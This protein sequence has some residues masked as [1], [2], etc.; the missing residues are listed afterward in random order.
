MTIMIIFYYEAIFADHNI[1]A[2]MIPFPI[3]ANYR[4]MGLGVADRRHLE[5]PGTRT[6]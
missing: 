4:I 2:L 3:L 6:L 1:S 5:G